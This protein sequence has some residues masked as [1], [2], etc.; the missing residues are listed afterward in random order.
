MR[1]RRIIRAAEDLFKRSGFRGVTMEAVAR[2]AAVSK[3]TLYHHFRNKDQ[4]FRAVCERMAGLLLRAMTDALDTPGASVDDRVRSAILAKHRLT[5]ATVRTS[6]HADE[7]FSH[8][9]SLAGDVFAAA[10]D[11]MLRRLA[12]TL[13]EDAALRSRAG[14][15]ARALYLGAGALAERTGDA[16]PPE[17]ELEDFVRVHLA[18]ARSLPPPRRRRRPPPGR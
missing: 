13:A 4:L 8:T 6:P 15:L 7:L 14:Q 11:E 5:N 12:D 9:A 3:A 1:Y 16:N 18:G 2:D 17:T 10:D